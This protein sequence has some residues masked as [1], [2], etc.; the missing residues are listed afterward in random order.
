MTRKELITRIK[1]KGSCLCVGL[2]PDPA[3]IPR[4]LSGKK[5]AVFQFNKAIIDATAEHCVAFKPNLAFYECLGPEGWKTF[6]DTVEYIKDTCDDHFIIADAK[7]G[8][9]GNTSTMYAEAFFS[10]SKCDAVTIAPY[11]GEDSVKPF[12]SFPGKW[13]IVLALTSNKGAE[14][15]QLNKYG[16]KFLYETV[17]SKASSWG[18]VEN[19]MFVA[20]A[21]RPETLKEIRSL[22]P[23]HF[24]LIPG[25]G[26]QGGDLD[27]V[28]KNGM[29]GDC[30]ILVNSSRNILYAG[31][32][33][34]FAAKAKEEAAKMHV[35]MKAHITGL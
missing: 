12:L 25:V 33:E 18:T 26:A 3:K 16:E 22:V 11:M 5:D 19:L 1:N 34:D 7:R 15:F 21:T 31:S 9:I 35:A 4:H 8:D 17:I 23:G 13:A 27:A 30:G 14:D 29:N 6:H 2:D 24:L 20:G 10:K 28:M 32:G